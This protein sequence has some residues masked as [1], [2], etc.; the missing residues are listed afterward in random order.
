MLNVLADNASL[1]VIAAK[2]TSTPFSNAF[3]KIAISGTNS[4]KDKYKMAIEIRTIL[5]PLDSF[6][7]SFPLVVF[8]LVYDNDG[9][10]YF[11]YSFWKLMLAAPHLNND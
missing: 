2:Y 1:S 5:T 11:T 10:I 3:I 4:N 9:S 7:F 8:R 6:A